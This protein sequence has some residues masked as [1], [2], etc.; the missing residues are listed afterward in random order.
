MS[1]SDI[2]AART[3][4]LVCCCLTAFALTELVGCERARESAPATTKPAAKTLDKGHGPMPDDELRRFID[5]RAASFETID[6]P[7]DLGTGVPVENE[8]FGELVGLE[9]RATPLLAAAAGRATPKV[10]AHLVA[11]LRR[12]DDPAALP[13]LKTLLSSYEGRKPKD[14]WT[15]SV[16]AQARLAVSALSNEKR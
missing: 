14:E 1:S 6:A 9:R 13:V 7:V 16:I 3:V 10:A 8:A 2:S 15:Q 12:R 5:R 11:I 4:A